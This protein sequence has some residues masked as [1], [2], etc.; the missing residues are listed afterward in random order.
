MRKGR[1]VPS[2]HAELCL[3]RLRAMGST[4]RNRLLYASFKCTA[5]SVR[6]TCM[7]VPPVGGQL[8]VK[9]CLHAGL[10]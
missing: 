10:L 1:G 9:P 5:G 2:N 3:R 6:G 7:N 4:D 8:P